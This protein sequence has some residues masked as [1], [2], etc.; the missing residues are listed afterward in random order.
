M[1]DWKRKF[2]L[3][4]NGA[5]PHPGSS[6][7]SRAKSLFNKISRQTSTEDPLAYDWV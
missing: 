6:G 1:K 5:V 4:Q 3:R 2:L 7:L